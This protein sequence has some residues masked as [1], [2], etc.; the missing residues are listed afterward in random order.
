MKNL[1]CGQNAVIERKGTEIP[2]SETTVYAV[3]T[4]IVVY[5]KTPKA[6]GNASLSNGGPKMRSEGVHGIETSR[7]RRTQRK[8]RKVDN[9]Q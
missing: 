6:F 5:D 9:E 2:K 4:N 1:R 8:K 3:V 7:K